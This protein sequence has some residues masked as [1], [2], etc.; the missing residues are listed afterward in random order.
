MS[1]SQLDNLLK[2]ID[3]KNT[4]NR[5]FKILLSL[6]I[7]LILGIIANILFPTF[8][9]VVFNIIWIVLLTIVI[10]FVFLGVLVIIGLKKEANQLLDVLLEGS[11]TLV[12]FINLLKEIWKRFLVL[13]KEFLIYAAPIFAYLVNFVF[14]LVLMFLFKSVG[15]SHDVTVLTFVLTI[16]L[17]IAVSLIN[18]PGKKSS[19]NGS[20]PWVLVFK[21]RF[22]DGFS[23][24]MEILLFLFFL[25]MDTKNL[26]FLPQDLRVAIHARLGEYDLMVRG[27]VYSDHLRTTLNLIIIAIFTEIIRNVIRIVAAAVIYY[28]KDNAISDINLNLATDETIELPGP[29]P[30]EHVSV[31]EKLK[32]AIRKSFTEIKD[33]FI[34]F[35]TY[36]TFLLFVFLLFPR[37]KLLTLAIASA[38]SLVLDLFMPSRVK[39]EP[40]T[41]LI[42]RVLK[43]IFRLNNSAPVS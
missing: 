40:K 33:D 2:K 35:V 4:T 27:F 41:D 9:S 11:L 6:L 23:D 3:E 37:L 5:V 12:D 29:A 31:S 22:R 39:P 1:S 21:Q 8:M 32:T 24:G 26:F 38:T 36:T 19:D 25:T 30:I 13:L 42:A 7:V 16:F 34:I 20:L 14:Y 18:R 15:K 28:K 10:V 17:V 43:K